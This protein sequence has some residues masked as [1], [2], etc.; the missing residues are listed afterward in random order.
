MWFKQV[1]NIESIAW[2]IGMVELWLE[3][4][5]GTLMWEKSSGIS[6]IICICSV[7]AMT[8]HIY[9]NSWFGFWYVD[10]NM[11]THE[12]NYD[13]SIISERNVVTW[14]GCIAIGLICC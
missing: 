8:I 14:E 5:S 3:M 4:T 12:A 10:I 1:L 9:F 7:P 6:M 13:H 2:A 11:L